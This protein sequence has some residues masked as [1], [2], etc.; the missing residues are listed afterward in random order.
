MT[1]TMP[2]TVDSYGALSLV[3]LTAKPADLTAASLATDLGAANA[4]NITC[5]V[6]GDWWPSATTNKVDRARK[7]CQTK[8]TQALGTT[9]HETPTLQYTYKPQSVGTAGAAGNEAYEALPEGATRYLLQRLGK[10]GTSAIATGDKYRLF[11]VELGPQI[12]GTSSEDEGGE[13]VI[14]QE[15]SFASGYDGPVNGTVVA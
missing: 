5:H 4:E 8:V 3:V 7:M 15:V 10:D 11:P 6:V 13:F 1:I 2:E 14:N 9:T 12:P